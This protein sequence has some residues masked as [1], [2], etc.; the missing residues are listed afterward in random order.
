MAEFI[1]FSDLLSMQDKKIKIYYIVNA[2]IPT[3]KAHGFAISKT[4][5]KLGFLGDDIELVL[6]TIGGGLPDNIFNYYGLNKEFTV[7]RISTINFI[8]Y[9]KILG[10]LSFWLNEFF[11]NLIL[12]GK[13]FIIRREGAVVYT[14]DEFIAFIFSFLYPTFWEANDKFPKKNLFWYK[15]ILRK[16]R[17]IV[18]V[19]NIIK[20][21]YADKLKF[22]S[23]RVIVARNAVDLHDFERVG[24]DEEV[25]RSEL[26]LP[27]DKT[28][29]GYVGKFKTVG[30]EKGVEF[31]IDC[32]NEVKKFSDK[33][34][35]C[36]V[37][38]NQKDID[39]TN[40][41]IKDRGL[42]GYVKLIGHV[43]R[44]LV[45]KYL[46]SF[47]I[48]AMPFPDTYHYRYRMSPIKMFE[49]M[50]AK[51]PI[52]ATDLPTIREVLDERN[53]YI[54]PS[55]EINY[56]IE[57]VR[58]IENDPE[59]AKARSLRA[60]QDVGQYTWLNRARIIVGFI[61]NCSYD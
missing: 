32:M 56:F 1:R 39:D 3:E 48:L 29:I 5:E 60:Y 25:M 51:K 55:D 34:L 42:E 4:C 22:N 61:K 52:I 44:D 2:R 12:A 49:Y 10:R 30:E 58:K 7:T 26:S 21:W 6:P 41:L 37:G 40:K 20:S 15:I 9:A 11:F 23:D 33:Y 16:I 17:G 47:D 13:F 24:D 14:R 43:G 19:N 35:L 28:I 45:V 31:L 18:V 59:E 50:A 46:K 54:I 8:R 38:G 27:S 53:A 57:A 36:C